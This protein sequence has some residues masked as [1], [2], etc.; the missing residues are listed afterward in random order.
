MKLKY[1]FDAVDMGEEIIAVPVGDDA[2]KIHGV[3]KLNKSGQEILELL[4]NDIT[5]DQIVE[6][7]A[8]KYDNTRE[9]LQEHAMSE[10]KIL[11][12]AGLIDE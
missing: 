2:E 5:I 7:L 6:K 11:K 4:K 1:I 10:I 3:L 12:D 8:L 9:E